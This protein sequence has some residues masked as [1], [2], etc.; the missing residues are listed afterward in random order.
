MGLEETV[1]WRSAGREIG[2]GAVLPVQLRVTAAVALSIRLFNE[3]IDREDSR[4]PYAGP[5]GC[6]RRSDKSRETDSPEITSSALPCSLP[7]SF[8]L[9]SSPIHSTL[10]S[11]PPSSLSSF[12][13]TLRCAACIALHYSPQFSPRQSRL[14]LHPPGHRTRTKKKSV[15]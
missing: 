8:S 12:C 1:P 13:V 15:H 11:S 9:P 6:G 5:G 2:S 14:R 3:N 4:G 7:L 10:T